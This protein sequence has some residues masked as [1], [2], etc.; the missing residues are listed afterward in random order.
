MNKNKNTPASAVVISIALA[1]V[2][3]A[4]AFMFSGCFGSKKFK[5]DYNGQ[6]D[7]FKNASDSYRAG[8]KVEI[9]YP[10]I[11]T[12]TDYS[13]YF[14]GE[15]MNPDYEEGKGYIIKFTMPEHD[16]SVEVSSKNTMEYDPDAP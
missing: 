8:E 6:K 16:V 9:Y 1:A 11:A 4:G 14:D 3:L 13:F 2:I 10:F 15:K 7:S 12:D 5:V